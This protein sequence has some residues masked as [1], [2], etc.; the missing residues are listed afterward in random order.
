MDHTLALLV[1]GFTLVIHVVRVWKNRPAPAIADDLYA[2]D[3][4]GIDGYRE[5]GRKETET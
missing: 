2:V 1:L 4:A 5:Q 3:C